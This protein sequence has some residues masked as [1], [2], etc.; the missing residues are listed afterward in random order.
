[1]T[2]VICFVF[3]T[4]VYNI[5]VKK[6]RNKG[7]EMRGSEWLLSPAIT[8]ILLTLFSDDPQPNVFLNYAINLNFELIKTH[9]RR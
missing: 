1:M 4:N 2:A 9:E 8:Y 5:F 3:L 7:N 6:N